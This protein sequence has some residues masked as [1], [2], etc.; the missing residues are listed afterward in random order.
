MPFVGEALNVTNGSLLLIFKTF[1]VDTKSSEAEESPLWFFGTVRPF[2]FHFKW[3]AVLF[4]YIYHSLSFFDS[5]RF[6]QNLIK[7]YAP[8]FLS[9]FGL[10][11]I[12]FILKFFFG[13]MKLFRK[14]IEMSSEKGHFVIPFGENV[15]S[16]S[17]VYPLGY[18][19]YPLDFVFISYS[20]KRNASWYKP[21]TIINYQIVKTEIFSHN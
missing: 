11:K 4:S 9:V 19:W 1:R 18:F 17:C 12:V 13:T 16:E 5:V 3:T 2:Y 8:A 7:G 15:V 14:K 10:G 21:Y 6:F 20:M